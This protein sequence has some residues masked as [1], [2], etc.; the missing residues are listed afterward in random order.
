MHIFIDKGYKYIPTKNLDQ[1]KSEFY[2]CQVKFNYL[3]KIFHFLKKIDIKQMED[4]KDSEFDNII[5]IYVSD[6]INYPFESETF[7][8]FQRII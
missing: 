3:L 2:T 5:V 4:L 7:F 6:I 8:G 1:F